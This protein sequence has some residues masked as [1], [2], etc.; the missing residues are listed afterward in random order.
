MS[1]I[2]ASL[3]RTSSMIF[4]NEANF[5]TIQTHASRFPFNSIH[6][7]VK[8]NLSSWMHTLGFEL[9]CL[10]MSHV[11]PEKRASDKP[12]KKVRKTHRGLQCYNFA[13]VLELC[14]WRNVHFFL[15]LSSQV[16]SFLNLCNV[17]DMTGHRT[18]ADIGVLFPGDSDSRHVAL[19]LPARS[20]TAHTNIL[21][22]VK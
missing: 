16:S 7:A 10:T 2:R 5:P 6:R 11:K 1:R 21:T 17:N 14:W 8:Q 22:A 20:C 19:L 18:N 4:S 15:A 13:H 3:F 9:K 12:Q